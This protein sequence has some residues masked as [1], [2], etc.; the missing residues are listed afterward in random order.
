MTTSAFLGLEG[1][2]NIEDTVVKKIYE[3]N[4][5]V[6]LV[7]TMIANCITSFERNKLRKKKTKLNEDLQRYLTAMEKRISY[8][9]CKC[10]H[11]MEKD[12]KDNLLDHDKLNEVGNIYIL[13]SRWGKFN[14]IYKMIPPQLLCV[15]INAGILE[16]ILYILRRPRYIGLKLKHLHSEREIVDTLNSY[17][18]KKMSSDNTIELSFLNY[19]FKTQ[20]YDDI[21]NL[22]RGAVTSQYVMKRI[23]IKQTK[24][25]GEFMY[26]A[27]NGLYDRIPYDMRVVRSINDKYFEN[28]AHYMYCVHFMT[29]DNALAVWEERDTMV[30][31]SLNRRSQSG[32]ICIVK[33][34][35][36][37][38]PIESIS[39]DNYK[40][41]ED[42]SDVKESLNYG[43]NE[44][45]KKNYNG[46][47]IIDIKKLYESYKDDEIADGIQINELNIVLI[48][49]DI[50]KRCI[51][52]YICDEEVDELWGH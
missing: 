3:K 39:Y 18:T 12:K 35:I 30:V 25:T 14:N 49:Y 34:S 20:V 44:R 16:D 22:I 21:V 42:C 19:L 51:I 52:K 43:L 48:H 8:M 6:E 7:E 32:S 13:L 5:E 40:I 47:L 27:Y 1:L 23:G 33:K 24:E 46:G 4:N 10:L 38:T 9:V 31:K 17:F 28:P 36:V 11:N 41:H 26:Y 29:K 45:S 37:A 50:P 15:G 2:N